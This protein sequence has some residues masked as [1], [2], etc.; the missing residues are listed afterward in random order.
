MASKGQIPLDLRLQDLKFDEIVSLLK[1]EF[2]EFKITIINEK[3]I[4]LIHPDDIEMWKKLKP[5]YDD[6]Q[7]D[8]SFIFHESDYYGICSNIECPEKCQC[9]CPSG[10]EQC[11]SHTEECVHECCYNE[12]VKSTKTY[13]MVV[14]KLSSPETVKW[15]KSGY[16]MGYYDLLYRPNDWVRIHLG[17][18]LVY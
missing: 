5:D 14:Q 10:G 6:S 18:G 16:N 13:I 3:Q 12:F 9:K 8:D 2:S 4:H 7:F 17:F 1:K 15:L 11:C